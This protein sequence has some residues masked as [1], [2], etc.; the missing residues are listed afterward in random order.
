MA[1]QVCEYIAFYDARGRVQRSGCLK[2][3]RELEL[4]GHF[5]LPSG[6]ARER[7]KPSPGR[8]GEAVGWPCGVPS[9]VGEIEGLQLIRVERDEQMLSWNELMAGEHPLGAGP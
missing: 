5:Q 2:A 9:D 3:L 6:R 8:Q 7:R 4:A 1:D